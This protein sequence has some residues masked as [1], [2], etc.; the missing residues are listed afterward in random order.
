MKTLPTT[1]DERS[2]LIQALGRGP[3]QGVPD[4]IIDT[5][6]SYCM[7]SGL[8]PF[9]RPIEAWQVIDSRHGVARWVLSPGEPSHSEHPGAES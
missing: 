6:L 8:D 3:Y 4:D 5:I 7:A 1:L 9:S 2:A